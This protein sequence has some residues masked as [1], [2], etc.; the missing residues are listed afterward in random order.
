MYIEV[1]A[2]SNVKKRFYWSKNEIKKAKATKN[3]Y[4]LYLIPVIDSNTFDIKNL[5][6]IQN[7]ADK[8]LSDSSNWDKEVETYSFTKK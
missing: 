8:L 7:P 4:Y 6:I 3:R 5:E 2:I 1:K